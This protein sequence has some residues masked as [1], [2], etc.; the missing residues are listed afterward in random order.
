MNEFQRLAPDTLRIEKM[1]EAPVET[2]WRWLVDPELRARWFAGGTPIEATGDFELE[3]DHDGLS[4]DA[5]PYPEEF[6]K[7]K[8]IRAREQVVRCEPPRLLAFSW[9][10][11]KEGTATFELSP[12]GNRTRLVLTHTGITG[13]GPLASFG[14]GWMSHLTALQ[15]RLAGQPVRDFWALFDSASASVKAQMPPSA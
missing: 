14:S 12:V 13:P 10:G 4:D 15:R 9:G 5:V 1:L 2:V 11:G 7:Y 3:F 8:G 6:A